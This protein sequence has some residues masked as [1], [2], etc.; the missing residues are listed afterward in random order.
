MERNGTILF[1]APTAPGVDIPLSI[2]EL[3]W[4]TDRTL[5]TSYAAG[6]VDY[7][8]A[9]ELINLRRLPVAEMITH[10]LSLEET[11]LGFKLVADADESI[12]VVIEPQR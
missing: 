3:F 6:P 7:A 2:N 1:F 8:G 9:L 12:K 11:G 4:R 5:I 10:R